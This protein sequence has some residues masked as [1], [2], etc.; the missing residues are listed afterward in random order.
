[1]ILDDSVYYNEIWGSLRH[2]DVRAHKVGDGLSYTWRDVTERVELIEH[3]RLL[4]ENA[5]DVVYE[6]DPQGVIRWVRPRWEDS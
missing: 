4:A 5:S 1:M 3:F 2:C 6:T